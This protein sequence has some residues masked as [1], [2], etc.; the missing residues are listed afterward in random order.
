MRILGIDYGEKNTG[1]AISHELG[2]TAQPLPTL[3]GLAGDALIKEIVRVVSEKEAE[4]VVVGLPRNMDGSLGGSGEKTMEF[5]RKLEKALPCQVFVEDERLTT[6]MA[7]R[8]LAGLGE[9]TRVRKKKL[10]RVAAQLILQGYLDRKRMCEG[11]EGTEENSSEV[12][13]NL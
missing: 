12:E 5:V 11:H 9:S 7:D 6:M 13:K 2:I 8:M 1:L 10:D 4:E 3:R